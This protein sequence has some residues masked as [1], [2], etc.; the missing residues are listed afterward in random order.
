M[1][2]DLTKGNPFRLLFIFTIPYL[3]G[4]L[5]Q[6]FYNIADTVIVGRTLGTVP[7]AAVGAT[8]CLSWFA[9]G[10]V[11][12]I[13][14]GF[15]VVTARFFGSGDVQG[16]KKSFAMSIILS[17]IIAFSMMIICTVFLRPILVLLN[18]PADI[19][20]L[21]H[22]Y[23]F[24]IFL[25]MPFATIYNVLAGNI[26]ALGN[27]RAP[28]VFLIISAVINISCDFIFILKF[29]MNVEGA[30]Y[31][32]VLAQFVSSLL[33]LIY[34]VKKVPE[35]HLTKEDF[36]Y[37]ASMVKNLLKI[38]FPMGFLNMI[39]SIGNITLQWATNRLNTTAVATYTAACKVEQIGN[40]PIQAFGA[41]LSVYVAQNY[42]AGNIK[43]IRQGVKSCFVMCFII[44][45]ICTV[46][47]LLFSK[48]LMA[49]IVGIDADPQIISDGSI[50]MIINIGL[51]VL[52][53][54][55]VLLKA[56]LQP[57]GRAFIPTFSG[58]AE[59]VCRA[60][61]SFILAAQF[62]FMGLCYANPIAWIGA[63]LFLIP[64]YCIFMKKLSKRNQINEV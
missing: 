13:C 5:F 7:L 26:R 37:S 16:I 48:N 29:N 18:T 32:T 52:L 62:G 2:T 27:S 45:A 40:Q 17:M 14:S 15:S 54:P 36:T 25:G 19:V 53:T 4:N 55:V 9:L 44:V 51:M 28:L 59:A 22:R 41:S 38:G 20:N 47:M 23:M 58:F 12:G 35:L 3:L 64:E 43:R 57:L 21:S 49:L 50:F 6:Q 39:L 46:I 24:I 1:T 31:A 34:I 42:G 10:F 30:A 33:C 56:T 11:L 60:G 63:L 8:G 61:V